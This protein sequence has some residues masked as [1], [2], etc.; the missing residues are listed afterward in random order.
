[1]STISITPGERLLYKN[2]LSYCYN[3][4]PVVDTYMK[5]FN[6]SQMLYWSFTPMIKNDLQI[7]VVKERN[8]WV[9]FDINQFFN[10][11]DAVTVIILCVFI[12]QFVI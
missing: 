8:V 9:P 5:L 2:H 6:K 4:Y 12:R 1:M 7:V 10:P 3:K 11:L